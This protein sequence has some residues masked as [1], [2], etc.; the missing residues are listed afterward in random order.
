MRFLAHQNNFSHDGGE[1][2]NYFDVLFT[3][4]KLINGASAN[5]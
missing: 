3:L 4:P 2:K 5:T 1:V